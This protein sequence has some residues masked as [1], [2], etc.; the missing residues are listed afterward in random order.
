[1]HTQDNLDS[2][3]ARFARSTKENQLDTTVIILL[4]VC[5]WLLGTGCGL[6]V[7]KAALLYAVVVAIAVAAAV[8]AVVAA[9][10]AIVDVVDIVWVS[11]FRVFGFRV[12][13][14][15]CCCRLSVSSFDLHVFLLKFRVLGLEFRV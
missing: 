15:C 8:A 3:H 13:G 9:V 5:R 14:C 7:A 4:V 12:L 6:F 10:A 11:G 1:M 2:R